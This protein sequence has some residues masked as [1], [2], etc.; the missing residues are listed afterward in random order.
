MSQ[1]ASSHYR[2]HHPSWHVN[3]EESTISPH[4]SS[5]SLLHPETYGRLQSVDSRHYELTGTVESCQ[6][7]TGTSRRSRSLGVSSQF[8]NQAPATGWCHLWWL[9]YWPASAVVGLRPASRCYG[10]SLS[11]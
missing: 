6:C 8:A 5:G 11:S 1:A 2:S 9:S 4:A 3:D 10:E 7:R